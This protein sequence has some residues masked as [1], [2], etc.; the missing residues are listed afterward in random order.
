MPLPFRHLPGR[1]HSCAFLAPCFHNDTYGTPTDW[2][3][4]DRTWVSSW[5]C[6]VSTG[7]GLLWVWFVRKPGHLPRN[8]R[9]GRGD[10][11][12]GGGRGCARELE[13][14]IAGNT[15]G[16]QSKFIKRGRGQL[17]VSPPPGIHVN[18]LLQRRSSRTSRGSPSGKNDL[19]R[20]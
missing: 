9:L 19:C 2:Y 7:C 4:L 14:C 6:N 11:L 5:I 17:L 8:L 12:Y 15:L 13:I 10:E 3:R 20:I 1:Y 18:L 16:G